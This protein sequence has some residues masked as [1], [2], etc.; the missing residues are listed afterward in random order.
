MTEPLPGHVHPSATAYRA[1][2]KCIKCFRKTKEVRAR[3]VTFGTNLIDA[4]PARIV[5]RKYHDE[6]F[7]YGQMGAAT[8]V[9]PEV[10]RDLLSPKTRK[11]IARKD[12]EALERIT[13]AELLKNAP[14]TS[15]VPAIGTHRRIQAL[16]YNGWPIMGIA[17][18]E[19]QFNQ[20]RKI[21]G[22]SRTRIQA[23]HYRWMCGRFAELWDKPGGSRWV[24][25]RAVRLGYSPALA[26]DDIDDPATTPHIDATPGPRDTRKRGAEQF[27]AWVDE[28]QNLL[29]DGRSVNECLDHFAIAPEGAYGRFKRHAPD[30]PMRLLITSQMRK[31]S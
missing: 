7:G 22:E 2:C 9:L 21:I 11:R 15:V 28:F 29:D 6:G 3:R 17:G 14:D 13:R 30:H 24:H 23:R 1:G 27:W 12:A 18:D 20:W 16:Q 25:L 8:G 10:P 31:V 4:E 26:W 19:S 5:V